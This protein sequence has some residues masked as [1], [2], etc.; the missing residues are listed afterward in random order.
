MFK[1]V[2]SIICLAG[3]ADLEIPCVVLEEVHRKK[4][5]DSRLIGKSFGVSKMIGV[6]A[7]ASG[8]NV[9]SGNMVFEPILEEEV[10][11]FDCSADDRTA[12]FPSLSFVNQKDRDT[13]LLTTKGKPSFNPTFEC[14][15]GQQTVK[16]EVSYL[17]EFVK[18]LNIT[19]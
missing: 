3:I 4:G 8:S 11:R 2:N 5:F 17:A 16:I 6:E 1:L 18:S 9:Q 10:F 15:L 13:P 12:A 7:I 19:M 14:I